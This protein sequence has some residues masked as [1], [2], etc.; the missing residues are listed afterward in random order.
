MQKSVILRNYVMFGNFNRTFV[1]GLKVSKFAKGSLSFNL[2]KCWKSLRKR[3]ESVRDL[4][5]LS[6]NF[7]SLRKIF[8]IDLK[9]FINVLKIIGSLTESLDNLRKSP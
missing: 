3:S 2:W 6:E 8:D 5:N 7:G 1:K 9:V 4:R